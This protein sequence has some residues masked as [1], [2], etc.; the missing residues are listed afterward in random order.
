MVQSQP[1][2][3]V[4]ERSYLEKTHHKKGL[5]EWLKYW[6]SNSSTKKTPPKN[7]SLHEVLQGAA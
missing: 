4:G 7:K 2:Q 3:T 5:M 6:S 1:Q